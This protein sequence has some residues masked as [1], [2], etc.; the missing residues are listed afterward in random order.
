MTD[1]DITENDSDIVEQLIK[2]Y[3]KLD[4]IMDGTVRH[5]LKYIIHGGTDVEFD[6]I[7]AWMNRR[8]PN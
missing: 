8:L 5:T 2:T 1:I 3:R 4:P 7:I 6:N